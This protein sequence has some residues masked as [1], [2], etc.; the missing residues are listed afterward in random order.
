MT[1]TKTKTENL[2]RV[3]AEFVN[4][5]ADF[6]TKEEKA[7][8]VDYQRISNI[9]SEASISLRDCFHQI[10]LVMEETGIDA[11]TK[12][13]LDKQYRTS[14]RVLQFEDIIQQILDHSQQQ[15]LALVEAMKVLHK[16]TDQLKYSPSEGEEFLQVVSQC[17]QELDA[18][19][20][21]H[22]KL[23]PVKQSSLDSGDVELF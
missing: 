14:I 6:V 2:V 21:S 8:L 9:L 3:L 7:D 23:N 22:G 11:D 18:L 12:L 5:T 19:I 16:A 20:A 15:K 17:R 13:L 1:Q 10:D 4:S